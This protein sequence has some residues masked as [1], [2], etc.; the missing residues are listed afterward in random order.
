MFQDFALRIKGLLAGDGMAASPRSERTDR[1]PC[2]TFQARNRLC[3]EDSNS[4]SKSWIA[5]GV[6]DIA[7]V[8]IRTLS[9]SRLI[10]TRFS[11]AD[12]DAKTGVRR[13]YNRRRPVKALCVAFGF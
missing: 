2:N 8:F 10:E 5:F 3:F 11:I 9:Q 13:N 4:S 6:I 12:R 1:S 7:K